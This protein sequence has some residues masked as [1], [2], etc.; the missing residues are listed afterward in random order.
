MERFFS[1]EVV[2]GGKLIPSV[3]SP[4]SKSENWGGRSIAVRLR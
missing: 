1:G 4:F 3:S 2:F